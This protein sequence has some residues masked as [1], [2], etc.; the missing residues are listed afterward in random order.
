[1]KHDNVLDMTEW[2]TPLESFQRWF[3]SQG[4][5]ILKFTDFRKNKHFNVAKDP[6]PSSNRVNDSVKLIIGTHFIMTDSVDT[7]L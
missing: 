1:M 6:H 7:M 2:G 4:D 3:A 5:S